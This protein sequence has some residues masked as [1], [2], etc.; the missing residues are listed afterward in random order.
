MSGEFDN[1]LPRQKCITGIREMLVREDWSIKPPLGY[2]IIRQHDQ[3]KIVANAKR[4]ASECKAYGITSPRG[5]LGQSWPKKSL[6]SENNI[7]PI[8]WG[9]RFIAT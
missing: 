4:Q 6:R 7:Y 2:D 3:R 1:Q 5:V 9:T 8:A